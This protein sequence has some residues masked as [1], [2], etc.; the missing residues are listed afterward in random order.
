MHR[1]LEIMNTEGQT[2]LPHGLAPDGKSA[3][4]LKDVADADGRK[5]RLEFQSSL[6]GSRSVAIIRHNPWSRDGEGP[7]AGEQYVKG[8]VS[9]TGFICLGSNHSNETVEGSS[10]P[11]DWSI[12]RVNYFINAFS[13]M[14]QTGKS[15]PNP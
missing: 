5:Y 11:L 4:M 7:N 2:H 10:Y 6:D 8:H 3:I 12:R 15:F 1:A 14:K 9:S 13:Y